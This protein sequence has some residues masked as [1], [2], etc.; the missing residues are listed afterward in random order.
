MKRRH[1]RADALALMADLRALRPEMT[2]GADFIAGFPTEDEAM[3]GQTLSLIEEAGLAYVHVFP[4]SPRPGT[5]AARMPQLAPTLIKTRAARLR[6]AAR[7][8]HD[9]HLAR[10]IGRTLDVLMEQDRLGRAGNFALVNFAQ[11]QP[12]GR[13]FPAR[14]TGLDGD[15]LVAA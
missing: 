1:S 3:F 4:F 2:F 13:V 5:P 14:I 15:R 9:R 10:Q 8:A 11:P 7:A 6:E 12:Y